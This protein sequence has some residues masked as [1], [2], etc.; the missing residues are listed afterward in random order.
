MVCRVHLWAVVGVGGV[1]LQ[2][3]AARAASVLVGAAGRQGVA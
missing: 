3:A 1:G 2:V